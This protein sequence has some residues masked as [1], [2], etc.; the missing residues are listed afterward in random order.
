MRDEAENEKT[1]AVGEMK[2]RRVTM[3]DGK[4]YLIYYTFG[5]ESENSAQSERNEKMAEI[6]TENSAVEEDKINV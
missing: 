5:G 4:R 2:K 6:A 1:R 3:A